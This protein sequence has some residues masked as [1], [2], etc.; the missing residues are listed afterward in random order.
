VFASSVAVVSAAFVVSF[1]NDTPPLQE[2]K[3]GW[4]RLSEASARVHYTFTLK[5][6]NYPNGVAVPDVTGEVWVDG[7][8]FCARVYQPNLK[9]LKKVGGHKIIGCNSEYVF[10]LEETNDGQRVIRYIGQLDER[11]DRERIQFFASEYSPQVA[12]N[13]P[14]LPLT[15]ALDAPTTKLIS[16]TGSVTG[17][18]VEWTIENTFT[19]PMRAQT[20]RQKYQAV[21]TFVT[22]PAKSWAITRYRRRVVGNRHN[23]EPICTIT[24]EDTHPLPTPRERRYVYSKTNLSQEANAQAIT[25]ICTFDQWT[26]H[27]RPLPDELF[28]ISRFG[29]PEPTPPPTAGGSYLWLYLA[30]V[31]VICMILAVI[32]RRY[33]R[34]SA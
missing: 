28:R 7:E 14:S 31:A 4:T 10:E 23:L 3:A 20:D 21:T 19:N 24:Y 34:R 22:D 15:T 13:I 29:F 18:E 25:T 9:D 16:T 11:F 1:G 2:A 17:R 26:Y 8:R 32:F 27:Q 6:V 30:G 5:R 12:W 33:S